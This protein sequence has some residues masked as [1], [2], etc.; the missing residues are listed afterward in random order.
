M[1][2]DLKGE[3]LKEIIIKDGLYGG[4]RNVITTKD[5]YSVFIGFVQDEKDRNIWIYKTRF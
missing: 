3:V 5:L 4:I 2:T 1:L